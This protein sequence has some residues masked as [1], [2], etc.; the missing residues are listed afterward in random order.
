MKEERNEMGDLLI[1]SELTIK[2]LYDLA[3]K[4]GIENRKL[5]IKMLDNNGK[6]IGVSGLIV[7]LGKWWSKDSAIME[8]DKW[9]TPEELN[10]TG[11]CEQPITP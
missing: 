11:Y 8:V 3:C 5:N 7:S 6:S 4:E 1:K 10:N 2:E 9:Y